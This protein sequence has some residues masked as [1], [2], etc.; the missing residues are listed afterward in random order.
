MISDMLYTAQFAALRPWLDGLDGLD[1]EQPTL[2][3][4]WNVR[5]L[6]AHLAATGDSIAALEPV[7]GGDRQLGL[8]VAEYVSAY[9]GRAPAIEQL[10]R[11]IVKRSAGDVLAALDESHDRAQQNLAELGGADRVV[12]ARRGPILLS[13]FLDTRVMEL[14][15]HSGDLHRALPDLPSPRVLSSARNRVVTVLREILT[16]RAADPVGA[17]QAASDLPTA[18]FLDLATGR[19]AV[20]AELPAELTAA[21]P[22]L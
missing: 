9:A 7:A 15:V 19:L 16:L 11:E 14:V 2:L 1:L 8:S 4:G 18:E 22:L 20:P 6:I 5:E 21:L 17:L 10:A 13:N 3:P 12:Q